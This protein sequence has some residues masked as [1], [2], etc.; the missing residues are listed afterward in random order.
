[1]SGLAPLG[2]LGGTFDPIHFGHL[3]LAQELADALGLARVRFMPTGTPPHRGSPQVSGEH[4][5]QMVRIA[6]AGNSAFEVDD[7]EI[8]RKGISYSYDTLTELR[9]EQGARPIC[10]LMGTDAFAALAT[11]HRWQ[12][13]FDLAHVV[14][15]YRP[16]F[17]F[18]E[19]E[20]TLPAPLQKVYLKRLA[21]DPALLRAKAG[22]VLTR[23]ITALDISAT[24]IRALITQGTSARYLAPDDVL[25][26]IEQHHLYKDSDA[27]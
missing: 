25:E 24:H 20:D 27:R 7:R 9:N 11:W 14:I 16:G 19:L 6:T 13:L 8:Q 1:M 5:L 12:E 26:Y 17:R 3:R 15:A 22:S 23:E 10:L 21:G 4:R 2:V 18:E